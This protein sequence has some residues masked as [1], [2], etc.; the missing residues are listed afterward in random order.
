MRE[1]D[2]GMDKTMRRIGRLFLVFASF[3]NLYNAAKMAV[4]GNSKNQEALKFQFSLEHELLSLEHELSEEYYRPGPYRFFTIYEPK[5]KIIAVA[6]FRDRVV[7]H[8]LVNILEPVFDRF[9][10]GPFCRLMPGTGSAPAATF[11][12]A[13]S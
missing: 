1:N 3:G 12:R 8:A 5:E 4:R 13:F 2:R 11:R 6:P 10:R 9:P 7:H